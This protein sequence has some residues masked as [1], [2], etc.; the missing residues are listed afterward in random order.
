MGRSGLSVSSLGYGAA[1]L[2]NLYSA[3]SDDQSRAAV[4][5]AW[6]AGV[7]YFDTA[8]H[9][10]L[11]LSERR[12]G[13]ALR[14][15][16][17]SEF[18][19][20][21][22]VGRLLAPSDRGAERDLDFG[23][24]VPKNHERVWDFSA[25]GVRRSIEESLQRLG[26]DRIDV[27]LV[28]DPD[29]HEHEARSGALPE[30]L[31]LRDEGVVRAVGAG[32]NASAMLARFVDEFDLD[33][34]LLAGC[35]NLI[36]QDSLDDLMPAALR[37]GTSIVLG[38]V[39]GSGLL[40]TDEPSPDATYRYE[41]VTAPVLARAQRLAAIAREHGVSLPALAVQFALAHPAVAS[42]VL[43]MRHADEVRANAALMDAV[44]PGEVWDTLR[45]EGLVREDAP[46]PGVVTS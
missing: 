23:F 39:Y 20:Q 7:R 5:A 4:D 46:L 3:V 33:V 40:A 16:P 9:Y 41:P 14:D 10:G 21:T 30:L 31:K 38:G 1:P 24:D 26:L 12:T 35:Y 29:D 8:P 27:A 28:H 36:E 6:K 44:I 45:A 37:R 34:V 25:S 15:R 22:K 18:V 11:G 2:G 42:A 19:L 17:R 32:M 43:G 13:E